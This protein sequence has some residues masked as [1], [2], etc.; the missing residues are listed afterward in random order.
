[1]I[2]GNFTNTGKPFLSNDPHL[3]NEIPTFWYLAELIF[4]HE[5]E[6]MF[7]TGATASLN[8]FHLIYKTKYL[9]MG[10]TTSHLDNSDFY[11]E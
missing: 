4:E 1:V 8:P 5:G 10:C 3:N 11:E 7:V 6:E 2:H 9:A